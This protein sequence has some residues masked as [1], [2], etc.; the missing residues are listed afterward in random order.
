MKHAQ[1]HHKKFRGLKTGWWEAGSTNNPVMLFLHG[2]PDSP[3]TWEFQLE[4]FRK[5]FYC[6]VPFSRGAGISQKS[7]RQQ[8]YGSCSQA[9]DILQLL[10]TI[11]IERGRPVYLVGHDLGAVHAWNVAPLLGAQLKGVVLI[12]GLGMRPMLGRLNMLSQHRKSWYIY[13]M[14]VPYLPELLLRLS[15]ERFLNLAH[16]LGKLPQGRRLNETQVE[17]CLVHTINQYRAFVR[18]IPEAL[19]V[20]PRRLS[21]PILVLWGNADAFLTVPRETEWDDLATSVTVRLLPAGH[22]VHRE[23]YEDVN[24]LLGD[25]VGGS[26]H[27]RVK[28]PANYMSPRAD[29]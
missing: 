24:R 13:G 4:H 20:H 29:A 8:R 19:R 9:L 12:N 22:W 18:E 27:Y 17:G 25:F 2:Y 21:C 7:S 28:K 14:Q 6:I 10:Q 1:L 11:P 3:E 16:R 5:R 15:P 23:R 26:T